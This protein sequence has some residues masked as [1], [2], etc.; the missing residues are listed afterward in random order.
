MMAHLAETVCVRH[1][2]CTLIISREAHMGIIAAAVVGL[3]VGFMMQ[4][5]AAAF[6]LAFSAGL[7]VKIG[8][9]SRQLGLLQQQLQRIQL[10]AKAETSDS[11]GA[12]AAD[13]RAEGSASASSPALI[14]DSA[15]SE[16]PAAP[17][18][19]SN[20]YVL[21]KDGA[22]QSAE[23][24]KTRDPSP[25][26][27]PSMPSPEPNTPP[28]R[29]RP[30]VTLAD[31]WA[32]SALGQRIARVNLITR[33][34]IVILF[35]GISFLVKFASESVTV[36][37]ELRLALIVFGALIV[38]FI[39]WRLRHSRREYGLLL[40]GAAVG[41]GYLVTFAAMK[42]YMLLP[43]SLGFFVLFGLSVLAA[44]LSVKQDAKS[45]AV[46]GILGGFL[47]PVLASTGGGSH[48]MLFSYYAILNAGI[49]AIV[50]FKA[51]R[52][53]T[54]MGFAFTFII[55]V[56]WGVTRYSNALFASTEPFLL[57]FILFYVAVVMIFALRKQWAHHH[58]LDGPL[59]FGTP[60]IGFT[61]QA[62]M[63]RQFEYGLAWSAL[64]F[65]A[66][67]LLI[68]AVWWRL[69]AQRSPLLRESF[70][71]IGLIF[72]SLAI[73]FA[74]DHD[75]T[76]LAWALEGGGAM[77]LAVRQQRNWGCLLSIAALL[78]AGCSWLFDSPA[79]GEQLFFNAGYLS[80][81]VMAL[82]GFYG[83]WL[84]RDQP[85][86][87]WC[88]RLHW[89]LLL[90]SLT[91]WFALALWQI[92][93][94][95]SQMILIAAAL[96]F[97]ST[98]CLVLNSLRKRYRWLALA[99]V[100]LALL[101][102]GAF[103][104]LTSGHFVHHP[105]AA[106]GY[107]AWPVL[108]GSLY[109]IYVGDRIFT[110]GLVKLEVP[111]HFASYLLVT[112]VLCREVVWRIDQHTSLASWHM[113]GLG[114]TLFSALRISYKLPF[115]AGVLQVLYQQHIV[116]LYYGAIALMVFFGCFIQP[117]VLPMSYIPVLNA[118]DVWQISMLVCLLLFWKKHSTQIAFLPSSPA[119]VM[120]G[121]SLLGVL[122][123][124]YLNTLLLRSLHAITGVA[125][126][127]H[128]LFHDDLVQTCLSIFWTLLGMSFF[129]ISN[130]Q[131][132][133]EPWLIGMGLVAVVV[134]KLF[135]ID[136]A[137]SGTVERIV[138]FIAVGLL[139]LA[140]GYLMPL[141]D[142]DGAVEEQR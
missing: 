40:Q 25:N 2:R 82:V 97:I 44:L 37:I 65:G 138:S 117:S 6:A 118:L 26:G 34:G 78:G 15:P 10:H 86:T 38:F 7:L 56:A 4:D 58:L 43:A 133:R 89:P 5:V 71:A 106:L 99:P 1:T 45:L 76:A 121:W 23:Q 17:A 140:V 129:I 24:Q 9:L 46:F 93:H 84:L 119:A 131:D 96:L 57:L 3:L 41:S 19:A 111:A 31:R 102:V 63:V 29:Q 72:S 39:G 123:F 68:T 36:P 130:R 35:L 70:L 134:A 27:S 11:L 62:M 94:H 60:V 18:L 120:V 85:A 98:S 91:W 81:A 52:A 88:R 132:R 110:N 8:D 113:I 77:W 87:L 83:A 105:F 136:L 116:A 50:W 64:G 30:A 108:I 12:A 126:N 47:A 80:G 135:L 137:N 125:F 32:Q 22:Q 114:L 95:V 74:F 49:V 48:V 13:H 109:W 101:P 28:S 100:V 67:Y 90:W 14:S 142:K 141:P 21:R 128:A 73:P 20:P 61:L 75:V 103:A 92:H 104:L 115:A 139:L 42:I 127:T 124:V 55:S 122:S 112:A 16:P 79:A 54:L 66:F 59:V 107:L 69:M 51:W 53:L 33:V